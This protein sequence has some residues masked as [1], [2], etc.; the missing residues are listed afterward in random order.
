MRMFTQFDSSVGVYGGLI[1]LLATLGTVNV[2]LPQG[3]FPSMLSELSDAPPPPIMAAVTGGTLLIVY[4]ALGLIGLRLAPKVGIPGMW[5]LTVSDRQRF[6]LPAA[7]GAGLG[8]SFIVADAFVGSLHTA[9]R[10][11]HPPFPTS[12]VTSVV[13]G[14]GEETVFRLFFIPL[15]TWLISSLLLR[16]QGQAAAFWVA[17]A[18][19]A[20]AF[21]VSHVPMVVSALGML[22]VRQ[23]PAALMGE[24]LVLNGVL[25]ILAACFL[26]RFG[27]LSVVTLH[28]V[29][30]LVWH[31]IGGRVG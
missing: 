13:A 3:A 22:S 7:L 8:A 16:G 17:A 26:R 11:P 27:F 31:V 12:L 28:V 4:G 6:L 15:V 24:I 25:S 18:W 2:L 30:D 23:M 10:L 1:L 19:S 21:A 14:I 5:D 20:I 9:G 29:T